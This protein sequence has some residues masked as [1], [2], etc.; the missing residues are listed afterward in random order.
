VS[1]PVAREP[2]LFERQVCDA[3]GVEPWMIGI[4][5]A[6]RQPRN[7]RYM[8]S[9]A[10]WQIRRRTGRHIGDLGHWAADHGSQ[11]AAER[12]WKLQDRIY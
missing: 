1:E 10:Q 4:G 5:P 7:V 9:R 3:F 8:L 2:T 12:L 6:P 11:R